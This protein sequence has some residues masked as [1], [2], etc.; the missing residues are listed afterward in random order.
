MEQI[1]LKTA[2]KLQNSFTY[3]TRSDVMDRVNPEEQMLL[4]DSSH[5]LVAQTL[6]VL[7]LGG[8]VE[9]AVRQVQATLARQKALEEERLKLEAH[10]KAQEQERK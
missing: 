8:E 6:N 3:V 10:R 4:T 5:K 1:Y 2:P 9:R 7:E